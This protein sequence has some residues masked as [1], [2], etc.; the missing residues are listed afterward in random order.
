MLSVQ[1]AKELQSSE[2]WSGFCKEVD[3]RVTNLYAQISTCTPEKLLGLQAKIQ[4]YQEVKGILQA[5]IDR[6]E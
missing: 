1:Q 5:V 6:E 4:V 2:V 3:Q